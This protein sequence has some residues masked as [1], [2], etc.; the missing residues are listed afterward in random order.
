MTINKEKGKVLQIEWEAKKKS[1]QRAIK[2]F[3]V[4]INFAFT[5]KKRRNQNIFKKKIM[6]NV[7]K[8]RRRRGKKN[9]NV[10]SLNH[11]KKFRILKKW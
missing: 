4:W 1:F 2:N 11:Q 7:L 6:H 3:F 5:V 10:F 8:I 9:F